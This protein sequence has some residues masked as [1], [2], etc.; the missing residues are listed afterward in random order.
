MLLPVLLLGVVSLALVLVDK[1]DHPDGDEQD[2]ENDDA[3][4]TDEDDQVGEGQKL[5][6]GAGGVVFRVHGLHWDNTVGN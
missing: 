1:L 5:A 4:H 3:E 6:E 2:E